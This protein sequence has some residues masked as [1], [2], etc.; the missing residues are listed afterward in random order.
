MKNQEHQ[1]K[2]IDIENAINTLLTLCAK[3][4]LPM[5]LAV[6]EE[7]S[8]FRTLSTNE[9]LATGQQMKLVKMVFRSADVDQFL[10]ELIRDA[11]QS[12]HNSLFLKAMGIP[13]APST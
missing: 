9:H 11:Q 1:E 13:E 7:P 10:R 5:I 2:A 6:Q 3:Q 12:G 4:K 8:S